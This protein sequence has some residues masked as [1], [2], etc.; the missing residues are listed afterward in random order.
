MIG[1]RHPGRSRAE[2]ER[3]GVKG[4]AKNFKKE[5]DSHRTESAD[6]YYQYGGTHS[7]DALLSGHERQE[8]CQS[9]GADGN[10]IKPSF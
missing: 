8:F 7:S 10:H 6:K 1:S 3:Q 4:D 5:D 9:G 2:P